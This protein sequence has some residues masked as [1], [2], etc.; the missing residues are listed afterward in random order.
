MSLEVAPQQDA[1][2]AWQVSDGVARLTLAR[3]D[4]ANTIGYAESK[5][6]PRAFQAVVEAE[7]RVIVL[8]A[9]GRLFCAGGDISGMVANAESLGPYIESTLE[10]LHEGLVTL[11][12]AP[13]PI[14]SAWG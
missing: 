14:V 10:P 1:G 4:A 2:I 13:C 11:A 8:A 9:Q 3:P 5:A 6:W 7:P 12:S